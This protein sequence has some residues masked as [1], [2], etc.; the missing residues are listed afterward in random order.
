[1]RPLCTTALKIVTLLLLVQPI[2]AH[3]AEYF[4]CRIDWADPENIDN[5]SVTLTV[6]TTNATGSIVY[7]QI[8]MQVFS[9]AGS[10]VTYDASFTA[11]PT[12]TNWRVVLEA[13]PPLEFDFEYIIDINDIV[14]SGNN[15]L[16]GDFHF[17]GRR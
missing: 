12:A 9:T 7:D 16:N 1:M 10:I 15:I 13:D 11:D 2:L 17:E 4:S 3:G 8:E 14:T 6:W 5:E